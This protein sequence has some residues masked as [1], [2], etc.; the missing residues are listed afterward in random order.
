MCQINLF[1]TTITSFYSF[2]EIEFT[3]HKIAFSIFTV[4]Q[5]S[6]QSIL[7]IF[8]TPERNPIPRV[9]Q[10]PSHPNPRQFLIYILCLDLYVLYILYKH[11]V[12][13]LLCVVYFTFS[14]MFSRFIY[15]V[16]CSNTYALWPN[17]DFMAKKDITYLF[18]YLLVDGHLGFFPPLGYYE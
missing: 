18:I 15:V 1:S 9:L 4:T 14:K 10:A 7:E 8:I 5:P 13:Y 2:F 3:Y 17:N 11:T 6:S 16:V 12:H